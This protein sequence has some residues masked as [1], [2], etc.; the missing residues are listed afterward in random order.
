MW[1]ILS[2][3]LCNRCNQLLLPS[4]SD[5]TMTMEVFGLSAGLKFRRVPHLGQ[6]GQGRGAG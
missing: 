3:Y 5:D 6:S 4:L 1:Y 2:R